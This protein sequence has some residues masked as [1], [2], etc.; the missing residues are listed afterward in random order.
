MNTEETAMNEDKLQGEQQSG[1]SLW[2]VPELAA[3]QAKI[4]QQIESVYTN[5]TRQM[6]EAA[7]LREGFRV[8]DL[9]AGPGGQS[10]A[11]AR[12]VGATGSVL[13]TDISSVM[14]DNALLLAQQ[15]GVTN[16]TTRVMNAEQLELPDQSFDAVIS[17]LGL[18]LLDF[19]K[20]FSEIWRVLKPQRKL[21]VLVW[22]TPEHHPLFSIRTTLMQ[23]YVSLPPLLSDPFSL[24]GSGVFAEALSQAGF[25]AISIK[26]IVVEFIYDS[27]EAFLQPSSLDPYLKIGWEQLSMQDQQSYQQDLRQ[28]VQQFEGPQGLVLPAEMLLGVGTK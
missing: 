24:G 4:L 22:S 27:L 2:Q 17:R 12:A 25:T 16:I 8:L 20:A 15:E 3:R 1:T 14:L 11:A 19:R 28:A 9:A 13:A 5:A 26:P 6:L 7:E 18:N 21:A 10:R 23:R